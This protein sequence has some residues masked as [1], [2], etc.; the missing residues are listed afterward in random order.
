[1]LSGLLVFGIITAYIY[2]PKYP[3][4]NEKTKIAFSRS[5]ERTQEE[6]ELVFEE[7]L[8]IAALSHLSTSIKRE[9]AS[10]IVF[11]A[12]AFAGTIR[13]YIANETNVPKHFEHCEHRRLSQ[14]LDIIVLLLGRK[15]IMI[16]ISGQTRPAWPSFD[17]ESEF[18]ILTAFSCTYSRV[19]S[20]VQTLNNLFS[21]WTI[22]FTPQNV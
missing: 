18:G 22:D 7:L 16:R 14:C 3:N 9:L 10:I 4:T 5:H 2:I 12:H 20:F 11:E 13:K 8:H 19:S 17:I 6:L 21:V 1:M 15:R